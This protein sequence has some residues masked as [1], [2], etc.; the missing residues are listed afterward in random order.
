MRNQISFSLAK[1]LS[2]IQLLPKSAQIGLFYQDIHASAAK[3]SL[4]TIIGASL[5]RTA[6]LN[7]INVHSAWAR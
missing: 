4:A 5:V 2:I 1:I 6:M 3:K 7:R